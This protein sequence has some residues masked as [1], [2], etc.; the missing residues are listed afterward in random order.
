MP[1]LECGFES[2][3]LLLEFGPTAYIAIG[4]DPGWTGSAGLPRLPGDQHAALIDTGAAGSCID[5]RLA[6]RLGLPEVDRLT[7]SGVSGPTDAARYAAQMR[8]PEL[9]ITLHGVFSGVR[10][11]EGGHPYVAL[12]GRD[13]LQHFTMTYMGSTGR[14]VLSDER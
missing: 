12:L 5:E 8:V 1:A 10:L 13:L 4:F 2:G 6:Q 11:A 9:G 14:V 3:D 7:I